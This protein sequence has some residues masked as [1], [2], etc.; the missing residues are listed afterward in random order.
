MFCFRLLELLFPEFSQFKFICFSWKL[1]RESDIFKR[2][3]IFKF[4]RYFEIV[5][6]F[7]KNAILL[8][9]MYIIMNLIG[10]GENVI[11]YFL[12][13]KIVNKIFRWINQFLDDVIYIND[14]KYFF[15]ICRHFLKKTYVNIPHQFR[16]SFDKISNND[17][18]IKT[19]PYFWQIFSNLN[20]IKIDFPPNS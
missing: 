1:Y 16:F 13:I 15:I 9:E 5:Y 11:W 17:V 4:I 12:I 8:V 7:R 14:I 18:F 2:M 19:T 10:F 3:K 20:S 6:K